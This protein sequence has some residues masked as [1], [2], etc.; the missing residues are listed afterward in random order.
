MADYGAEYTDEE[1]KKLEKKIK[2]VYSQA[3]K[4]ITAKANKFS[5]RHKEQEAKKLK[6]VKDGKIT[7]KDFDKW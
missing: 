6:Q 3:D 7:Q 2:K 5:A 4:E 1:L